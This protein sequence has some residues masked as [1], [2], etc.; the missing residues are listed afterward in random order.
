MNEML[1]GIGALLA[2]LAGV[3]A[4]LWRARTQGRRQGRAQANEEALRDAHERTARGRATV[5]QGRASGGTPDERLR[6]NDGA[7]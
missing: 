3:A 4:A 2:L 6:R 7:W 5:S 1:T